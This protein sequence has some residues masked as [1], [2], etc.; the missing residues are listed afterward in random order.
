VL[1]TLYAMWHG[2]TRFVSGRR[3]HAVSP[4][5]D[6]PGVH[7]S[8]QPRVSGKRCCPLQSLP[9]ILAGLLLTWTGGHAVVSPGERQ[10]LVNLYTATNGTGWRGI[11]QGWHNHA[12]AS[13][14]PCDPPATRWTGITC[15]G[16]TSITCVHSKTA[17]R[18]P[19][20]RMW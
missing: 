2:C 11:T 13:V 14:D 9:A 3:R 16:T 15:N 18:L 4:W 10:G 20:R 5:R 1:P 6:V 8:W 12:N 17:C 19:P 7:T